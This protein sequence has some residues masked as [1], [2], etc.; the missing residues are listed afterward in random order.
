MFMHL[1]R[2]S[3]E[4]KLRC[5]RKV[6]RQDGV[7]KTHQY[8]KPFFAEKRRNILFYSVHESSDYK[9]VEKARNAG[10]S[11]GLVVDANDLA[12]LG[13][14]SLY[15][16]QKY[17]M[18]TDDEINDMAVY[19]RYWSI[20]RQCC[21]MQMSHSW[22]IQLAGNDT[23]HKN[24]YTRQVDTHSLWY[25]A[26]ELYDIGDIENRFLQSKI[27]Q[28]AIRAGVQDR[29]IFIVSNVDPPLDGKYCL[30]YNKAVKEL[31]LGF[32]HVIPK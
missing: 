8:A 32:N 29:A 18:L 4:K 21:G 12:K 24:P 15:L 10:Y 30:R 31:N 16:Y 23:V 17:L 14:R 11:I 28:D 2:S 19:L 26:C 25:S 6:S 5:T 27:V 20:L 22:R 1:R 3:E 13:F 7:Y 9:H